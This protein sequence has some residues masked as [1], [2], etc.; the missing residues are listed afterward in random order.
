MSAPAT[1]SEGLF[2]DPCAEVAGIHGYRT[3]ELLGWRG[4]K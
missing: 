2:V 3:E 1:S 4:K